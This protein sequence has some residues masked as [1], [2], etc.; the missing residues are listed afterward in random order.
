CKKKGLFLIEDAAH[1]H[2]A[3]LFDRPAGSFGIASCFSFFATKVVTTGEGGTVNTN[4]ERL[5]KKVLQMR[6]H[7]KNPDNQEFEVTS[8]NY[9]LNELPAIIGIHQVRHLAAN[10]ERRRQIANR[11]D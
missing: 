2:G 9:R 8:N 11:Y 6:N 1:A 7:G 3:T 4:D 5:Y 10:V